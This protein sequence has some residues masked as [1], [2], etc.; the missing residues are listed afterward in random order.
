MNSTDP[1]EQIIS[2]ALNR[3]I[4]NNS[5]PATVEALNNALE[6]R[7]NDKGKPVQR[8]KLNGREV[9]WLGVG[10]LCL[11]YA[12]FTF[13]SDQ[14]LAW[15]GVHTQGTVIDMKIDRGS[16]GGDFFSPIVKFST[17][18][19]RAYQFTG[20]GDHFPPRYSVNQQVDV[21]Y[22]PGNPSVAQIAGSDTSLV[23][24]FGAF[25]LILTVMGLTSILRR[26]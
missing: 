23:L 16:K 18:D 11:G 19:E 7:R 25:G 14:H 9:L 6:K 8:R 1:T 13:I 21:I 24:V 26:R 10:L 4:E 22:D 5:D 17:G 3:A 12:L 15:I 2:N 20:E